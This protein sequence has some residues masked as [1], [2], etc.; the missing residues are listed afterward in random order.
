MAR[1]FRSCFAG[2]RRRA[3][4]VIG[5]AALF[6]AAAIA[7][8]ATGHA[9]PAPDDLLARAAKMQTSGHPGD[10]Y[11]LL[12]AQFGSRVGDPAYN[13]QLGVAA[14]DTGHLPEAILAFQRTLAIKPDQAQ[15]R[16]ELARAYA[17]LGDVDTA[18]REFSM[19]SS[20]QSIPDPVRRRFTGLVRDLDKINKPGFAA[21]GY[22]EAGAGYDSNVNA[23]TSASQLVI[24]LFSALGPAALSGS[25]QR[26]GDGFGSAEAGLTGEYG[27]DRQ[28]RL[29]VSALGSARLNLTETAFSQAFVAGTAG[30]SYTLASR[31][32]ASLSGQ[33]QRF[34]IGGIG[35]RRAYGAIG[36]YTHILP[37][38]QT[39]AASVQAFAI[40]YDTDP[41]RDA[42]RYSGVLTYSGKQIALTGQGG[43]E[44][45]DRAAAN[46]LSN[47]FYGAHLETEHKLAAQL[48]V[49]ANAAVEHRAYQAPDPLFLRDRRDTQFDVSAGLHYRVSKALIATTQAGYT[50]NQSNILLNTYNRATGSFTLRLVL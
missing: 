2:T 6:G 11:V 47:A 23:A 50:H 35:Y 3:A 17:M 31:D 27:F 15:A 12:I 28:S 39:L 18:R 45:T 32:V 44:R 33:V 20:D 24:P 16:A 14:L 10:A 29:F 9:Q 43:Y 49:F 4:T 34:W 7:L 21:S 40:R 1:V 26:Q 42:K 38:H 46:H 36:Q 37:D 19:V 48:S 8:G 41:L 22:V 5:R 13:Y 25:A 30:Y